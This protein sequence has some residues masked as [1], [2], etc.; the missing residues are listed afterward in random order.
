[1]RLRYIF[2]NDGYTAPVMARDFEIVLRN[3]ASGLITRIK[4]NGSG[5]NCNPSYWLPDDTVHIDTVIT[6]PRLAEG[7]YSVLLN[8]PDPKPLLNRRKEYSIQLA[9]PGGWEPRTGYNRLNLS[10]RVTAANQ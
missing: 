8:L 1:M 3:N 4:L 2:V 9:N 5:S 10:V 7:R 6:V